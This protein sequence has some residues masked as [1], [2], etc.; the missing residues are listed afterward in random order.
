MSTHAHNSDQ[1]PQFNRIFRYYHLKLKRLKGD[2]ENLARGVA[3]G[4]FIGITPTIPLHTILIIFICIFMKGSKVAGLLSSWLVSNPLT[5]FL[6]YYLSWKIGNWLTSRDLSWEKISQVLEIISSDAGFNA[7][8]N[9][10]GRLGADA[11]IVLVLGGCVL[12][13]PI[14]LISYFLSFGFFTKIRERNHKN[15]SDTNDS[16]P[17]Q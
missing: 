2:P 16:C 8:L 13:I 3:I 15:N 4:T 1:M 17:T 7:T 14:S 12:A 9:V 10:L 5:F 11:L 6:Q